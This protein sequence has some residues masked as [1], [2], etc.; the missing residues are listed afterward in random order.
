MHKKGE[1]VRSLRNQFYH[2][3]Q[4][5]I[6]EETKKGTEIIL[7]MDANTEAN[8]EQLKMLRMT[9]GLKDAFTIKHPE[10]FIHAHT[11]GEKI[12]LITYMYQVI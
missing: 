4:K 8:S 2:E 5:F 3:L 10:K 7:A 6:I 12:V 9:T 11:S 1:R